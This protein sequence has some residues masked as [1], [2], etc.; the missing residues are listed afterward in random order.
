[1]VKIEK[2]LLTQLTSADIK[3][4]F[5]T[6]MLNTHVGHQNV[7]KDQLK[8][9]NFAKES[10][11]RFE[12]RYSDQ[13]WQNFQK[14][15]DALLADQSFWRSA[16]KSVALIFTP[17]RTFIQ[18]LSI[19]VDD[20]YYVGDFPYLLAIIKNR[21]F[22]YR[23]YLLALNRDSMKVYKVDN[24]GLCEV[25]L[26][27][28]APINIKVALGEE[29]TGGNLN[30]RS[31]GSGNGSSENVAYHGGNAKDE[32]VEI[33][34]I[35]YYQAVDNFFRN[36]F[37]NEEKVPLYLCALPENQTLFKKI[38]K[39]TYYDPEI[40]ISVS[41]AQLTPKQIEGYTKELT[42]KL[43]NREITAYQELL[44]RKFVDQLVDID[45]AA[46]Q[47]RVAQLFIAT[48][49]LVDG[50]GENP[51]LEYD[52]RQILNSLSKQV[53]ETGG[54]VSILEQADAPAEKSL[55]AFLRY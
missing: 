30:F 41:P 22:S 19:E 32:E 18:R 50:F 12:K 25:E 3:G 4:P 38:A 29:L 10:K 33:D 39:T 15:I 36:D 11:K 40:A 53:I 51:D 49:N 7:E 23:Y 24:T 46:K 20:Q 55:V 16:E 47:G 45:H 28:Q 54:Q 2:D 34:W 27:Q 26:D 1:M 21:Q 17:Q 48:N 8:L 52:R 9:K 14:Q 13:D 37:P 31:L 6:I 42:D 44:N 35:N 5:V 43:K